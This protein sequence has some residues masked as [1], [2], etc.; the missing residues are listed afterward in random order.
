MLLGPRVLGSAI[1]AS[2]AR[3]AAVRSIVTIS[4]A[5]DSGN[6]EL[7]G[8]TDS[9]VQLKIKPDPF[10]ELEKKSH[11]QWFAF[12]ATGLAEH[13]AATTYE[14]I[15]AGNASYADAW[16]GSEVVASHDRISWVRVDSTKYDEERG[17]LTWEWKHTS[18]S[19]SV[20]FAYFDIYSY[21]RHLDLVARCTAATNAPGLRVH[22][23]GQSLDGREMECISVGTGPLQ[24]WVIHRQHPGEPMA[25]FFAEGLLS[26]LL[27]LRTS[28]SVDALTRRLLEQ[29][30]FHVVPSMNPDGATRGHLRT[31][32]IGSNLNREWA[33]TGEYEAPTLERS[34]EV[35][36]VLRSMD[37]SGVDFFCDI[38]GDEA[39]PFTFCAGGEGLPVWGPRLKA[40]HGAFVGSY[41]RANPDM[42]AKFGYE[43]DAPLAGNLAICSNQISNRFD[44]LGCTLEMPFK[45]AANVP[46]RQGEERGFD[47]SRAAM[48]GASL[49]DA[50]AYVAPNLRGVDEPSFLLP[51]DAYVAPVEDAAEIAKWLE[52]RK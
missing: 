42:Q 49:L 33:C 31:N 44:C 2:A 35:F 17:A 27:G 40:L 14:I 46:R 20:F 21:D 47:G 41:A 9:T 5:F 10:T 6:I 50:I 11:S 25:E 24:A 32:A 8:I 28:E 36:H 1:L 45:D 39:L 29:F 18:S 13:A 15:N 3:H 4:D 51:D 12:R 43:P 26:R 16:V 19:P 30:T 34:P 52:A 23:I 38:H 7:S 22:S 37:E 48:L